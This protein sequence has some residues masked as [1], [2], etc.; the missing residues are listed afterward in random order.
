M[1]LSNPISFGDLVTTALSSSAIGTVL[2][3]PVLR[4]GR[5]KDFH[6]TLGTALATANRTF[7]LAY[8]QPGSTTFVDITDALITHVPAAAGTTLRQQLGA[9]TVAYV[10][11][12]GTI[13]L[14]PAGTGTGAIPLG[15][16][17]TV[18]S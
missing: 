3:F 5:V 15:I 9:S 11:D 6:V 2:Y 16:G 14:T 10:Q 1:P 13:R 8:A 7:Q 4:P 17:F 12:G 18:G